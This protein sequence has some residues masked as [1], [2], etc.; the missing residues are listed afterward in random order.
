MIDRYTRPEM[1]AIWSPANKFEIWKQIE[2]LACEAQAELGVIPRGEVAV[3][4]T[5]AAFEVERIDEIERE[6]NHDVIAFLTNMAEHIGPE[7]KWVHYGMTSRD[8]G[9]TA[10]CYQMTQS[11]DHIIEDVR[12][13][14]R[15]C[16]ARAIEFKDTL[17]GIRTHCVHA[18]PMTFG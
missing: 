12:R 10:L 5:R 2:V 6:T 11:I 7:S 14:G 18:E 16:Q 8:L 13:P 17:C 3:I 9:D 1:G 15:I 4:R